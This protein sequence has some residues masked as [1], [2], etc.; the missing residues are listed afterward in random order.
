MI[1]AAN[2]LWQDRQMI[3]ALESTSCSVEQLARKIALLRL[4]FDVTLQLREYPH[5][6]LTE[7]PDTTFSRSGA[8]HVLIWLGHDLLFCST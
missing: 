7:R 2:P 6:L 4:R 1:F 3:F 5:I 8:I